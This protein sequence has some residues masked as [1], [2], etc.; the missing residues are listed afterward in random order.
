MGKVGNALSKAA[1]SEA[2][3]NKERKVKKSGKRNKGPAI[4]DS[5]EERFRFGL[6]YMP[7]VA[8]NIRTLRTRIL[9]PVMGKSP[10]SIL[11]TSASPGEGK[12]YICANLG[13]SL[14]QGVDS[15]CMVVDCDLRRPTQH[16]LFG[17]SNLKGV[18]DYLQAQVPLENLICKSGVPK[19][20]ILPCGSL[21]ENPSELSGSSNMVAL[22]EEL[23]ARYDDRLIVLD[24]PPLNAAAETAI[25]AQQVDG[26]VLVVRH[27]QSRREHIRALVETIGRDKIIGVVFNAYKTNLLDYKV[28]G[29]YSDYQS[30]YYYTDE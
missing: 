30:K 6:Q 19:L 13:L 5:W 25:L 29:Y 14:S 18:S 11:V 3:E 1:E 23:E 26:V 7:E 16:R 10:R 15:Y 17:V 27:G 12:S 21:P 2:I 4:P 8:E 22:I 28:F 9:Y 24:S 20:S